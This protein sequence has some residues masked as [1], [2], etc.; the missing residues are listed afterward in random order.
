MVRTLITLIIFFFYGCEM[1][2]KQQIEPEKFLPEIIKFNSVSKV[3]QNEFKLNSPDHETMSEIIQYWFDNRIKINGF[4]GDL[5]VNVKKIDFNREKKQDYY[6]FSIS[7]SIEFIEQKSPTNF[8]TYNV[9]SNEYGEIVGRFAINDQDNL[10]LNIMYKSL[11][12]I[13]TKLIKID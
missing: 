7:V 10:D 5:F 9:N 12:N 2:S 1:N 3:L 4:D 13:T 8:K 11:V 6:K